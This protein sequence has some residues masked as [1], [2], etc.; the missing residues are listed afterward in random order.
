MAK[1]LEKYFIAL[2]PEGE[3]QE[4]ATAI[5]EDLREKFNFKYALKSPAH[6]TLKMPFSWNELKEGDLIRHLSGFAKLHA[7]F[8]LRLSGFWHFGNRVIF[9]D[10]V[11]HPSLIQLQEA[12]A[13]FSKVQLKQV[14]ELSDRNYRPHMTV[15][16][17]DI[18]PKNFEEYWD[19]IKTLSFIERFEVTQI[20]LLKKINGIWQVVTQI[21]LGSS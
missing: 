11:S 13:K 2:V 6:V 7:P 17:K 9:I 18:K 8:N 15:A 3:I 21:P 12:L 4:K 20:A 19:Y 14:Q 1:K 5:K 10:V 16:F